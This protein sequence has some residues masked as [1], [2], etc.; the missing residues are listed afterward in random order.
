MSAQ[1]SQAQMS[2]LQSQGCAPATATALSSA[3]MQAGIDWS[4]I[5]QLIAKAKAVVGKVKWDVVLRL[6]NDLAAHNYVAVVQDVIELF[7]P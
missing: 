5:E 4:Y 3:A 7:T 1:P 6:I 2:A